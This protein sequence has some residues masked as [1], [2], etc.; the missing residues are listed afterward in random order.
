MMLQRLN[1]SRAGWRRLAALTL[2][3]F[4][5]F[6]ALPSGCSVTPNLSPTPT[7]EPTPPPDDDNDVAIAREIEEADI[8]KLD[9]NYL[10]L[11]N[12]Y[13]GLR[14]IDV[15][16]IERPELLGSY[17][18]GGRGVE[19]FIR[20]DFAFIFTAA[21]F[22]YC[23][24]EAVGYDEDV[25]SNVSQPD[26]SGTRLS[27][28]D[29]SDKE[30]PH[31]VGK[32]TFNGFTVGTRRVGDVIYAAGRIASSVFVIAVNVADP[33]LIQTVANIRVSGPILDIHVSDQAV[34]VIGDDQ[35]VPDT[36]LVTYVDISDPA[37][38]VRVRDQFR[39]PGRVR[40][41]FFMDAYANTFRIV[42]EERADNTWGTI[43]AL[44]TY[45]VTNPDEVERLARLPI[46]T[47]ESLRAVRFDGA[48]AY[49]STYR[50]VDPLF[51][52]DLA[53]PT[54]PEIAGELIVPGFSTHL[55]PLGDRLVGVGFDGTTLV[56]PVVSLYDVA[57]PRAPRRLARVVLS[58]QNG[59]A[60]TS[61]ATVDEKAL[62]VIPG[63]GLILLPYS[64]FDRETNEFIDALQLIEMRTDRLTQRGK[65]THR[66]LVRRSDLLDTRVWVLSDLAFQVIDIDNLTTP[67]TVATLELI[68]D[69]DL[70][71][72][73]LS[74]CVDSARFHGTDLRDFP[75]FWTG[76]FFCGPMPLGM[77]LAAVGGLFIL[78]LR[79]RR[80]PGAKRP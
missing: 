44:Y 39:V 37:G 48:R 1:G 62:R 23:A 55:V 75:Y 18:L 26:Y 60:I 35:S 33:R 17:P 31:L 41:R 38:S 3:G 53:N 78:R 14:I 8:I 7:P 45:D 11:S 70:L 5:V 51:V 12:P 4:A 72:A 24:G 79:P 61:E 49:A 57:N 2:C 73:G 36:T 76:V 22:N 80:R 58:D 69:Q 25:W 52:L 46:V 19:L 29:V 54:N 67:A 74:K 10:Y 32:A 77:M 30:S 43:V 66:G 6:A 16:T 64:Y 13:T 68:S 71:D 42:T 59:A 65:I 63:A 56:R 47:N 28:I 27:V 34:F 50:T 9:G 15:T 20:D 40:N 21:D